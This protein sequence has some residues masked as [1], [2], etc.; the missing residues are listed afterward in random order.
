MRLAKIL[1]TTSW[2]NVN[3]WVI[4][5][6]DVNNHDTKHHSQTIHLIN[7]TRELATKPPTNYYC[8]YSWFGFLTPDWLF[9]CNTIT[10]QKYFWCS[11]LSW[12]Y[13]KFSN[14]G[15][16]SLPALTFLF[17]FKTWRGCGQN[18][19]Q[20]FAKNAGWL[21]GGCHL[22]L[23]VVVQFYPWFKFSLLFV[24]NSSSGYYHTL[25]YPKT[26]E[27][28]IWTEDKIEPQHVHAN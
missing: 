10:F 28:K 9:S 18:V 19:T 27:K 22:H 2:L 6:G 7:W 12:F 21:T 26:K 13:C 23:Y 20:E 17:L 16:R 11:P 14:V 8:Y 1:A 4:R 3:Q 15:I 24:S 25:P 5:N